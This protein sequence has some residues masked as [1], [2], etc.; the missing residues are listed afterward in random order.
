VCVH[1]VETPPFKAET[2]KFA[3]RSRGYGEIEVSLRAK[4]E[5]GESCVLCY[6]I[7]IPA[8]EWSM[9]DMCLCTVFGTSDLMWGGCGAKSKYL[10]HR[11]S[12]DGKMMGEK[13]LKW[14]AWNGIEGSLLDNRWE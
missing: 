1:C 13:E 10:R 4:A 12:P 5:K 2:P 3:S 8:E 14:E 7:V 6:S 9:P 11:F